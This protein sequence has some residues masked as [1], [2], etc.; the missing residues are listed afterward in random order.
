MTLTRKKKKSTMLVYLLFSMLFGLDRANE[1][2][3]QYCP[4]PI[5]LLVCFLATMPDQFGSTIFTAF[6][7]VQTFDQSDEETWLDQNR[8]TYLYTYSPTYLPT[9]IFTILTI[10]KTILETCNIWDTDYNSD[11]WE[12]EFV[13]S[14]VTWQLRVT[15]EFLRCFQPFVELWR[16]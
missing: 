6:I 13:T 15:V 10:A 8:F 4:D 1:K 5:F 7:T 3:Q 16:H 9:Y 2:S 11:N 14:C 12:P